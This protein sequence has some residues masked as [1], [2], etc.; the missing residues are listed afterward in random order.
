MVPPIPPAFATCPH[1]P[2]PF[3]VWGEAEGPDGSGGPASSLSPASSPPPTSLLHSWSFSHP[4]T[5]PPPPTPPAQ[6]LS[7]SAR[8]C[9]MTGQ[10]QPFTKMHHTSLLCSSTLVDATTASPW[11]QRSSKRTVMKTMSL[12]APPSSC[13]PFSLESH[14]GERPDI[15]QASLLACLWQS[16]GGALKAGLAAR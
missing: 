2:T 6:P 10:T 13:H 12:P 14:L 15:K 1:L 3:R 8:Q 11:K 9:C 5:P 4:L 7:P 16:P